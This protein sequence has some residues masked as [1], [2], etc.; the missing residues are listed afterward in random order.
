MLDVL[1]RLNDAWG[2]P[3]RVT[4]SQSP[5]GGP[6]VTLAGPAGTAVVAI[7]GAQLLSWTP[8][9]HDPVVW[10]S[11]VG[12]LG[13]GKAVRG[14]TPIC[15]P[16]FGGHPA[17][18]AKPA[19][20]I[21][22]TRDWLVLGAGVTDPGAWVQLGT[23]TTA[24]DAAYWPHQATV[25]LRVTLHR[26]LGLE[27]STTNTGDAPFALSQALHTYFCVGEIADAE[28]S[29]FDGETYQDKLDGGRRHRQAGV[30]SFPGEVDRIYDA[31]TGAASI[32]DRQLQRRIAITQS[33][34]RSAVVWN[35]GPDKASRLGD[36]GPD[37]WKRFVCVET[38]NAGADVIQLNAGEARTLAATYAVSR[39]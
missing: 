24:A 30:I 10:L 20:G 21:V 14:G 13:T 22:R 5:L 25:R 11:P 2:Q 32:A 39:L 23:V 17:D 36:M 6:V 31:H 3:E 16:W 12:R 26:Q 18:P 35:P 1:N 37:G 27:L 29:G 34:S 7:Q 38:A 33:G 19:H 8:A 15:W 28:V 9:G 4:F